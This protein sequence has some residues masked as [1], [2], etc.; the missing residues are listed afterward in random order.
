[1]SF[2][3]DQLNA[4]LNPDHRPL[5]AAISAVIEDAIPP[6]VEAAIARCA[7]ATS[8]NVEA[9]RTALGPDALIPY[10]DFLKANHL[11]YELGQRLR[12][13]G[14]LKVLQVGGKMMVRR[15]HAA[16]FVRNLPLN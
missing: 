15:G 5:I 16:E 3:L 11:S 8:A 14:R 4:T 10:G 12:D 6:L 2:S 13:E 1:M 9:V 7:D